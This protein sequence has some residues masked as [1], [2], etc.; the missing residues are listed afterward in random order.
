MVRVLKFCRA[1]AYATGAISFVVGLYSPESTFSLEKGLFDLRFYA[2]SCLSM[3]IMVL[4]FLSFYAALSA[5]EELLSYLPERRFVVNATG[6]DI[7][8]IGC[9]TLAL[10]VT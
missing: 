1:G 5:E 7:T 3:D 10:L 2:L 4:S 8:I 9:L 6:T